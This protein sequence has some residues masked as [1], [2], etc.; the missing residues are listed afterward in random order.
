MVQEEY[1]LSIL[2]EN[3]MAHISQKLAAKK[4]TLRS[5]PTRRVRRTSELRACRPALGVRGLPRLPSTPLQ[6]GF[7]AGGPS[8]TAPSKSKPLHCVTSVVLRIIRAKVTLIHS[9]NSIP[10]LVVVLFE[11]RSGNNEN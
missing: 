8:L 4:L 9:F 6:F 5:G 2:H 1:L 10:S 3:V 7:P 11:P